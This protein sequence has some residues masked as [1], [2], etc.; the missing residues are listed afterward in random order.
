MGDP[1]SCGVGELEAKNINLPGK[2]DHSFQIGCGEG[3]PQLISYQRDDN[4]QSVM[5]Q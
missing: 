1:V 3:G 4:I 5:Q 2:E